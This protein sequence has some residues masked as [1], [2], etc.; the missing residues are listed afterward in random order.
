[1]HNEAFHWPFVYIVV[2]YCWKE[3]WT[4][5][6]SLL[7]KIEPSRATYWRKGLGDWNLEEVQFDSPCNKEKKIHSAKKTYVSKIE[8]LLNLH[9]LQPSAKLNSLML[10]HQESWHQYQLLKDAQHEKLLKKNKWNCYQKSASFF[11]AIFL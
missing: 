2:S 9:N 8:V 5:R 3:F 10:I 6:V 11:T 4:I 7:N 1:M